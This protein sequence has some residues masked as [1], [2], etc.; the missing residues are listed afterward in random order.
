MA[1]L[2]DR[3]ES[4]APG[5]C[6]AFY[7]PTCRGAGP[8]T[9][10]SAACITGR[11]RH[12]VPKRVRVLSATPALLDLLRRSA[13]TPSFASRS[14]FW[15]TLAI[16]RRLRRNHRRSRTGSRHPDSDT[17]PNQSARQP[18]GLEYILHDAEPLPRAGYGCPWG[19]LGGA[20]D[21]AR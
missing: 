18:N 11:D 1:K 16:P 20:K 17:E 10:C 19:W 7:W 13:C 15:S 2:G 5:R 8:L 4:R 14:C 9:A 21:K 12:F 3:P 6:R